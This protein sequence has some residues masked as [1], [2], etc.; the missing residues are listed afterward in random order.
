[1]MLSFWPGSLYVWQ[2]FFQAWQNR[3]PRSER[4]CLAWIIPNW[5]IF[6]LIPTKLP[7]YVLPVYPALA[8]ITANAILKKDIPPRSFFVRLHLA[9]WAITSIT[10]ALGT[11]LLSILAFHHFRPIAIIP[12][13]AGLIVSPLAVL[14]AFHNKPLR[15]TVIALICSLLIVG[16]TLQVILPEADFLWL[17]RSVARFVKQYTRYHPEISPLITSVG[18]HEPSLVFLLGTKTKLLNAKKATFY[19]REHLNTLVL[20]SNRK[21]P[22]FRKWLNNLHL[23]VTTLR[24]FKGFNYSKGRHVILKLYRVNLKSLTSL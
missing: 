20:V 9:A 8:L 11:A 6:E 14:N 10:M 7:H 4:F 1:M 24:V 15:A 22:A 18:Y 2:G 5:I 3:F 23:N 16:P 13:V 21:D 17:S 12:L 19:L